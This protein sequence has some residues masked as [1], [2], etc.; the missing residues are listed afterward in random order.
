VHYGLSVS[1]PGATECEASLPS[2]RTLRS[3]FVPWREWISV[4]LFALAMAAYVTAF[5]TVGVAR[6]IVR[7]AAGTALAVAAFG[8][9]FL[10]I[11]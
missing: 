3:T 2:G 8:T 7:T 6:R 11:I 4:V 1:P 5:G 10:G 9:F